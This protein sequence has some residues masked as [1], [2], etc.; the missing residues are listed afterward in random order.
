MRVWKLVVLLAGIVGVIGFFAPLIEYR[1]PDGRL[2]NDASAFD[3]ARGVDS[4]SDMRAQAEQLGFSPADS[5]RFARAVHAG[6][7]AY[8][9]AVAASFIPA[10]ALVALGLLLLLRDRMGRFSGLC[11]IVLGAA[12]IAV[13]ASMWQADQNTRDP[14]GSLGLGVYLL[15]AAGL[16]GGLAGLGALI[17]PDRG[18]DAAP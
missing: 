16:G 10:G 18:G 9:S 8:A 12:C 17:S 3:I 5:A 2:T 6:I 13:F 15:L 11:A 14:G 7:E 1:T 4:G